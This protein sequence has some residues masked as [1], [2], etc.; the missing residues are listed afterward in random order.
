MF[1]SERK[2]GRVI[3]LIS[4]FGLADPYV[5]Q[6]KGVLARLA[7]SCPVVDI[8]HE[9]E[10]FNIAQAAFFLAASA[11]YFPGD[12]VFLSVV[13]PGVGTDRRIVALTR[14]RQVFL[15]PDN[16]LLGLLLEREQGFR[17]FDMTRARHARTEVSDTFHGRDV[18][19]PLAAWLAMGGNPAE[20]GTEISTDSLVRPDWIRPNIGP[21]FAHARILHVDRFGNCV[22]N[23]PPGPLDHVR[24]L[25]FET[26]ETVDLRQVRTYGE[27]RP[28]DPG[29]LAGS[30]GFLEL[31]V[32]LRSAARRF[33]LRS[34]D[35]ITFVW[36]Q[37]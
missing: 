22:L 13:D 15:A 27:L 19:A 35:S 36:E 28:G 14:D 1:A 33:G 7:S 32:N 12:A 8:C 18:F 17:A 10:S 5:G 37:Q 29:L 6:M 4:D 34:G 24:N 2:Q 9:V 20:L 25:L 30:Q 31:S 26:S 3:A 21:G 23:I 11:P 16:G